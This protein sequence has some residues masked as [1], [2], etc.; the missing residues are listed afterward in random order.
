MADDNQKEIDNL[1]QI[2]ADKYATN[3]IRKLNREPFKISVHRHLSLVEQLQDELDAIEVKLQDT[4]DE[5]IR[6]QVTKYKDQV[7]TKLKECKDNK[8]EGYLTTLTYRDVNDIKAAVTEAVVHFDTYN[9]DPE[10]KLA[11]VIAEER[12]MTVF[13]ALKES[14]KRTKIFRTL[15]DIANVDDATIFEIYDLW[16]QEFVLTDTEIK[17]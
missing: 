16:E 14:D 7:A 3:A 11:R 13:C 1:K 12:Y 8:I 4:K 17:N 5:K 9:F 10:I 6:D 15:E 2:V